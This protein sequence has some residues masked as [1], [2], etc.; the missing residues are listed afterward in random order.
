VNPSTNK[1]DGS[2]GGQPRPSRPEATPPIADAPAAFHDLLAQ[3]GVEL[4]AE[5]LP[6]LADY[7]AMMLDENTRV[8]LTAITDPAQAWVRHIFDSLTLVAVVSELGDGARVIDVGTG[9]GVPGLPLAIVLPNVQFTLL[10]PTAKKAEFLGFAARKLK[11]ANVTVICDR[12]EKLGQ[13]RDE[14][15]ESY[16]GAIAR[17]VAPLNTL[18]ELLVP[19]VKPGGMVAAIKG[20]KAQ[21]ELAT[22]HDAVGLL[23][24]RHVTNM[25]TPT[26]VV[27][28]F[29]KISRTPKIYP[30]K[31]GEPK[32]VPLG[33]TK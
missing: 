8:N 32:R 17:A 22:A 26:G 30:R 27:V 14:Q 33:K 18:V 12:A 23:G 28:V 13:D 29:E 25:T 24:A 9:G 2:K 21:E 11:L 3:I 19:L 6:R 5:D 20:A 7:L 4:E 15:R 1:F 10:E 16:D 31:D